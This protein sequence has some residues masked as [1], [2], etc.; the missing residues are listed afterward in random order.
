LVFHY[1]FDSIV[2]AS[3]KEFTSP[4][5]FGSI[6]TITNTLN[7]LGVVVPVSVLRISSLLSTLVLSLLWI[8]VNNIM[9]PRKRKSKIELINKKYGNRIIAVSRNEGM[10]GKSILQLSDIKSLL[11]IADE[12][13]LPIFVQQ[14]GVERASYFIVDG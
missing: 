2:L 3:E 7:F 12:K 1:L 10:D 13:E 11:K 6:E 9:K 5:Q 8:Y 4:I 14:E